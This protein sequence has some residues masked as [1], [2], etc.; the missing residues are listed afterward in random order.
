MPRPIVVAAGDRDVIPRS[1]QVR[2]RRLADPVLDVL[3][4]LLGEHPVLDG[5]ETDWR[6][7]RAGNRRSRSALFGMRNDVEA[8][9]V[10][11]LRIERELAADLVPAIFG[12]SF[13]ARAFE[14]SSAASNRPGVAVTAAAASAPPAAR[15]FRRE[16]FM[17]GFSRVLGAVNLDDPGHLPFLDIPGTAILH[18][19]IASR[20]GWSSASIGWCQSPRRKFTPIP[21]P[22]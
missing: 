18:A 17:A 2:G 6:R 1:A 4:L 16:R 13:I 20:A 22:R 15:N 21:G 7:A 14:S 5:L 10:E 9:E 3:S 11:Q 8:R 19:S 12:T